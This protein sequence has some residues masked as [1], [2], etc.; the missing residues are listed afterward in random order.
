MFPEF[1]VALSHQQLA[2]DGG[3][4]ATDAGTEAVEVLKVQLKNEKGDTC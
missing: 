1:F 4:V 3:R 2:H